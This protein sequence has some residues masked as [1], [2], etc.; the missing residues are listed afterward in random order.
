MEEQS[1]QSIKGQQDARQ[2]R[3]RG[4]KAEAHEPVPLELP[5]PLVVKR[6]TVSGAVD[7]LD[8]VINL[9]GVGCLLD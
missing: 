9:F 1:L 3:G 6:Q 2:G 5:D 7:P 8:Y 4:C